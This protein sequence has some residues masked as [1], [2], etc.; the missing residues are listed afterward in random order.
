MQYGILGIRVLLQIRF[1]YSNSEICGATQ[2]LY[3]AGLFVN[4]EQFK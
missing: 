1:D 4:S 3:L 2:E